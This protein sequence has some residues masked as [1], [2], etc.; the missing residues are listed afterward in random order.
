[1][2]GK[3]RADRKGVNSRPK[4]STPWSKTETQMLEAGFGTRPI[5]ELRV[6]LPERTSNAISIRAAVL[7]LNRRAPK[8]T[9]AE[10]ARLESMRTKGVAPDKVAKALGRSL[11]AVSQKCRQLDAAAELQEYLQSRGGVLP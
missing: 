3:K 4:A 10:I 9:D 6:S 5:G 1:M 8:W 11:N 7:G 2:A